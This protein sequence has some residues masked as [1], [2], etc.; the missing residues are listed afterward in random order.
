MTQ[1]A[2]LSHSLFTGAIW[3]F[4]MR[5]VT[6][7]FSVV[8]IAVLARL[9]DKDDFG[10][11][12]VTSA[13][14]A[15]PTVLTDL[16][17]E[18]AIIAER[19]P[20]RGIY[21]TAWTIRVIQM[22]MAAGTIY[23]V[24]PWIADFYGDPRILSILHVLSIMVLLKGLE[25]MWTVAFR[26]E[27]NF[28]LD[29]I[30]D[31]TS[32]LFAAIATISL[33]F[34][35]RSYWAL[36]YGQVVAAA[37]RVVIS[38]FVAPEWPRFTLSHWRRIWSFS[39]WSLLKGA[40][41]YLVQS[42]DRLVLGRLSPAAAVGAYSLGREIAEMPLTEISMPVNRALGPGFSALQHDPRRLVDALIKTLAA[43][44]TIALPVG[45]GLALTAEEVIPVFLGPGW[46]EAVPIL[47]VLSIASTVTAVRGVMGNTL[48]VIGHVRSSAIVMWIRGILLV[49]IGIPFSMHMG[50]SGMAA[51]FFL[52]EVLTI[53][54]TYYFYRTQLPLFSFTDLARAL[55]R[56]A[57]SVLFMSAAVISIEQFISAPAL[58][59]L[60]WK[61]TAGIV[62]YSL[63]LGLLWRRS[64]C[65]D[66]VERLVIDRL[67]SLR[68]AV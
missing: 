15:L 65:P 44:A 66:G 57:Q 55:F 48:V 43:V 58:V 51:A 36:V 33:A 19:V 30:Y 56:P 64:G 25:N 2:S 23:I 47:Q 6:R 5:W 59:V 29:F 50:A 16:G 26:K 39:Q 17:V 4:L 41:S 45:F 40:A 22:A 63:A 28:R 68:R 24:S 32:R 8:S 11:V 49:G 12:A 46:S 1:I 34:L 62:S 37:L 38:L 13:V 20:E 27:L 35:L 3:M 18:Q 21:N 53:C 14:V 54:A 10:L 52:S 31:T 7:V 42:G 61:L 9:L 60:G 67:S